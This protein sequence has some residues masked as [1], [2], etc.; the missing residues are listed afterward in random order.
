MGK[1]INKQTG[2]RHEILTKK[3]QARK[4]DGGMV[5]N[6]CKKVRK[7]NEYGSNKS[8]CL[9]CK[10]EKDKIKYKKASYKLW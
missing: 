5:C 1:T 6:K 9:K 7:L 10:R 4:K 2:G 3:Y 8:Y